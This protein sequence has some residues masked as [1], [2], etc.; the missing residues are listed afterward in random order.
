VF[1]LPIQALLEVLHQHP[2]LPPSEGRSLG[3][4]REGCPDPRTQ[5][6]AQSRSLPRTRS[7]RSSPPPRRRVVTGYFYGGNENKYHGF[8]RSPN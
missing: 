8:L 5:C 6:T 2:G 7:R 1:C 3:A 4:F